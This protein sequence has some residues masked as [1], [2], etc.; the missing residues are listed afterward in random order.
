[1]YA[2]IGGLPL[3][4]TLAMG[5]PTVLMV[6]GILAAQFRAR[7]GGRS[8]RHRDAESVHKRS[9]PIDLASRLRT[10]RG[11]P[12]EYVESECA[13]ADSRLVSVGRDTAATCGRPTRG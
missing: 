9:R 3:E 12:R 5:G 7:I 2:H 13:R 4:E 1:M 11:W 10:R 8:P 6:L